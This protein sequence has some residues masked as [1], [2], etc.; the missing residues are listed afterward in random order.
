MFI[1]EC[2]NNF[3][4]PSNIVQHF[5]T[6]NIA[7][8]LL[9][10]MLMIN[11]PFNWFSIQSFSTRNKILNKDILSFLKSYALRCSPVLLII[12]NLNVLHKLKSHAF[13]EFKIKDIRGKFVKWN[14]YNMILIKCRKRVRERE[15]NRKVKQK[16]KLG[17]RK[18]IWETIL[19]IEIE[20]NK[21]IYLKAY[22]IP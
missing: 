3:N 19:I 20:K 17:W 15:V 8:D 6:I 12:K 5:W 9:L 10:V 22:H 16:V 13:K 2:F 18:R 11:L 4:L 7:A 14:M 21:L 1:S